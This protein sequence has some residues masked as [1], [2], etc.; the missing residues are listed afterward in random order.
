MKTDPHE[1]CYTYRQILIGFRNEFLEVQKKLDKLSDYVTMFD[2]N[3]DDYY[4]NLYKNPSDNDLPEL[5]IDRSIVKQRLLEKLGLVY[6]TPTRTFMVKDNN[7]VYY[8]L[9]RYWFKESDFNMVIKSGREKEFQELAGEILNS[10]FAKYMTLSESITAADSSSIAT[11]VSPRI[12]PRSFGF[13]LR[14]GKSEITYLGRNNIIEFASVRNRNEPWVPLTQ[15][16]L[17]FVSSI[18]FPKD[19][20]SEY[21]KSIIESSIDD[22]RTIVLSEQY[23]PETY[24]RLEIED[25]AK[26]L[27]LTKTQSKRI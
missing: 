11:L 27:V 19:A 9:R 21:H 3:V 5:V 13:V 18:E 14:T 6:P 16:H 26:K 7:G 4:F 25:E 2:Q 22:D 24:T 20:F 23:E 12:V 17:D 10:N 1:D 8:P 15:K